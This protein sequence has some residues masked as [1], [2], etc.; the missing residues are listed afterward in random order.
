MSVLDRMLEAIRDTLL[1]AGTPETETHVGPVFTHI[2]MWDSEAAMRAECQVTEGERQ[3][4]KM[5]M[6]TRSRATVT[7]KYGAVDGTSYMSEREHAF[8]IRFIRGYEDASAS[9]N[10]IGRLFDAVM[11]HFESAAVRDRFLA[12]GLYL[13]PMDAPIIGETSWHDVHCSEI[14]ASLVCRTKG[15]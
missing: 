8:E 7:G 12:L 1:E 4:L 11:L 13:E 10:I 6:I 9:P 5:A 2:R 15:E 14:Q 3:V